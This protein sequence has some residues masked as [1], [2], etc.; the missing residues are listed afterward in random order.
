MCV[1]VCAWPCLLRSRFFV[2][3][4]GSHGKRLTPRNLTAW[5]RNWHHKTQHVCSQNVA[6]TDEVGGQRRG[7]VG[8]ARRTGF[9]LVTHFFFFGLILLLPLRIP[10]RSFHTLQINDPT[11]KCLFWGCTLAPSC[12][13][14][15]YFSWTKA[16]ELAYA[17]CEFGQ[18]LRASEL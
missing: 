6:S 10:T 3:G 17:H 9:H 8:E 2:S 12:S 14:Y 4:I 16:R 11:M 1:C 15:R 18:L 7:G 13:T 5:R